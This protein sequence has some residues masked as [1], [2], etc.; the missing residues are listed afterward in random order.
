M[1]Y[2][3]TTLDFLDSYRITKVRGFSLPTH[4][5]PCLIF[6]T[7]TNRIETPYLVLLNAAP[8]Q[9]SLVPDRWRHSGP[10]TSMA[11]GHG[12]VG[13]RRSSHHRRAF[14]EGKYRNSNTRTSS[15]V[16]PT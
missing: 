6:S 3:N 9:A 4:R 10:A 14:P 8:T 16:H 2:R 11:A 7:L 12:A 1:Q 15:D 13:R 5:Y